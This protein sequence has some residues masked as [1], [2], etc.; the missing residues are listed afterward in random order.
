M[1]NLLL[2]N[3]LLM[4]LSTPL[5]L[6]GAEIVTT[7]AYMARPFPGIIRFDYPQLTTMS[8][9]IGVFTNTPKKLGPSLLSGFFQFHLA[10]NIKKH[11]FTAG[12]LL[13]PNTNR[14]SQTI[15]SSGSLLVGYTASYL[16]TKKL[17]FINTSV[18]SGIALLGERHTNRLALPIAAEIEWGLFDWLT[19]GLQEHLFF[20]Y[21]KDLPV[22]HN[23]LFY[24]Y[25]DHPMQLLSILF[26]FSQTKQYSSYTPY[27]WNMYTIH[28]ELSCDLATQTM[29]HLP[30]L[31]VFCDYALGSTAAAK[32]Q[33]RLGLLISCSF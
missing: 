33:S 22:Q 12:T 21:S 11:I 2:I 26:G 5:V 32:A 28:V 25:A 6:K 8:G 24:L 30:A 7:T 18:A 20:G 14:A 27:T 29:P 9:R 15:D 19:I 16:K 17:D 4:L 3:V 31:Q 1:K 10:Q 23:E 13:L